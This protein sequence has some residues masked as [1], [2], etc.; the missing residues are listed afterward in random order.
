[1]DRRPP[2]SFPASCG[3]CWRRRIARCASASP[4]FLPRSSW[5]RTV[6][7]LGRIGRFS[8]MVLLGLPF[9]ISLAIAQDFKAGDEGDQRVSDLAA[10]ITYRI[11]G[12]MRAHDGAW[13]WQVVMYKRRANG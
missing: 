5:V 6:K 7:M 1:M 12:G 10:E 2:E 9:L 13:P 4:P 11:V 8:G 3:P